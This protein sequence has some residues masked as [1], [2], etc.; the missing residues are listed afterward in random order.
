VF[1]QN[2]RAFKCCK[3]AQINLIKF[4]ADTKYK[5]E[6]TEMLARIDKDLQNL[7]NK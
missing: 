6:A 3:T 7:L 1:L 5:Q 2:G 4:K